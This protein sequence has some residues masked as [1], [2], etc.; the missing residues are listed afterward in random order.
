MI[1]EGFKKTKNGTLTFDSYCKLKA[2]W[3][4]NFGLVKNT[5]LSLTV[6]QSQSVIISQL[7]RGFK[8][9]RV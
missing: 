6:V 7:F 1:L 2:I 5:T 9:F 3:T 8:R 4:D